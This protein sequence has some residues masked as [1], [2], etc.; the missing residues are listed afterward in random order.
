MNRRCAGRECW[1]YEHPTAES[2]R[3]QTVAAIVVELGRQTAGLPQD[4]VQVWAGVPHG[5]QFGQA[6][7]AGRVLVA[8]GG[9]DHRGVGLRRLDRAVERRAVLEPQ[10]RRRDVGLDRGALLHAH[11]I[12]R[13]EPPRGS[14]ANR[15]GPRGDGAV[16]ARPQLDR[17]VVVRREHVAGDGARDRDW[18][19]RLNAAGDGDAFAD[20]GVHDDGAAIVAWRAAGR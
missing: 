14:P 13:D 16:D 15:D 9:D 2:L 11:D 5:A 3:R 8:V 18:L 1:G 6:G 19:G 17:D 12:A 20:G 4:F 10:P 7:R